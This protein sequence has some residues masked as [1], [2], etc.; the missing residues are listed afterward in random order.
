MS[1]ELLLT[2]CPL[3]PSPIGTQHNPGALFNQG[4]LVIPPEARRKHMVIFGTTRAG[5]STLMRNMI[6]TDIASGIGCTIVDPYGQ[7]VEDILNNH[8]PR[9]HHPACISSSQPRPS[10]SCRKRPHV[11]RAD[12]DGVVPKQ[13]SALN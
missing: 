7:L 13:L 1:R 11:W 10:T 8:I 4:E 5:K 3:H 2:P 6:A 12:I 9:A